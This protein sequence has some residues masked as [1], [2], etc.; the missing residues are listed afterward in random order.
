M[1]RSKI[2]HIQAK[3]RSGSDRVSN[4]TLACERCN[5]A[6]NDRPVAELLCDKPEKLAAILAQAQKPLG[7][8]AALNASRNAL[9][10]GLK[11]TELPVEGWTGGRTKFN[12]QTL[13]IPKTHALDG[14]CVGEVATLSNWQ[15]QV[16]V[17]KA[18]GRG[19]YQRTR[20]DRFGFARGYL[21]REKSVKGF[22]TGDLVRA[23]VPN[24]KNAGTHTGRVAVRK[25]GVFNI[26]T[27]RDT[28]AD[29]NWK[30]C[31]RVMPGDGYTY[32]RKKGDGDSS[33]T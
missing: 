24:G 6:K 1:S 19:A 5:L 32:T 14:A 22:R 7:V 20:L 2:E 30:Y 10:F 12:R 8:A 33:G 3:G 4:L 9:Y 21:M 23:T 18:T 25:R 26:Q 11:K 17:I 16:L 13:G 27:A 31:R 15:G 28:I 29:V